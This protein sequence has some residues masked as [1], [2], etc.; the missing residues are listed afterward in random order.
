MVRI[1]RISFG[2]SLVLMYLLEGC[3][4]GTS[5]QV[6]KTYPTTVTPAQAKQALMSVY[7]NPKMSQAQKSATMNMLMS[8]LQIKQT[9][10]NNSRGTP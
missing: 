1:V 7:N 4:S 10:G 6:H 2:I 3:H 5:A 8:H 9:A